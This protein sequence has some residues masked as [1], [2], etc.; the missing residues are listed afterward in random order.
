MIDEIIT[1]YLIDNYQFTTNIDGWC[2][3]DKHLKKHIVFQR[4][5]NDL[6][7]VFPN[8][9]VA[10][11]CS[12][13]WAENITINTKKIYDFLNGYKLIQTNRPKVWAVM[14][15]NKEFELNDLTGILPE[16][17]NPQGVK[18][19]YDEWFEEELHGACKFLIKK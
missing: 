8:M 9:G 19:V 18:R 7:K 16:H 13:W 17:F 1:E 4:L 3:F 15:G 6:E 14:K 12:L 11:V 5:I 2:V 10:K